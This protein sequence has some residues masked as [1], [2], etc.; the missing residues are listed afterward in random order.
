M[1]YIDVASQTLLRVV[2]F[3]TKLA[4]K[5]EVRVSDKKVILQG[6][7]VCE[8]FITSAALVRFFSSVCSSV[9][10]HLVLLDED[11]VAQVAGKRLL[12]V[13]EQMDFHVV[14]ENLL[15]T[16]FALDAFGS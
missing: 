3:I 10:S 14:W 5:R 8:A 13:S 16:Q 15:G 7:L 4:F 12:A 11:F 6:L 9:I 1:M 2:N